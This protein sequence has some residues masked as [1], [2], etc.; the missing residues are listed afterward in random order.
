MAPAT[1]G[2]LGLRWDLR[3]LRNTARN[4]SARSFLSGSCF[5][6]ACEAMNLMHRPISV[7]HYPSYLRNQTAPSSSFILPGSPMRPPVG[8]RGHTQ[9]SKRVV[10]KQVH[11]HSAPALP[12]CDFLELSERRMATRLLLQG[13]SILPPSFS[14]SSFLRLPRAGKKV[15]GSRSQSSSILGLGEKAGLPA[16]SPGGIT[17]VRAGAWL[18]RDPVGSGLGCVWLKWPPFYLLGAV[19]FLNVA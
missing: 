14:R 3:A 2:P 10:R 15:P 17:E 16:L 13:C 5:R 6:R 4:P 8:G 1:A 12:V 9:G 19:G 18:P 7:S 11:L